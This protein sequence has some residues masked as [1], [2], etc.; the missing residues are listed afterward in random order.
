MAKFISAKIGDCKYALNLESIE[1]V[2]YTNRRVYT[3]GA[4]K[5]YHIEDVRTF[6]KICVWVEKNLL[7]GEE[8]PF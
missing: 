4:D 2:D 1:S 5:A 8:K 6:A 7:S 3:I